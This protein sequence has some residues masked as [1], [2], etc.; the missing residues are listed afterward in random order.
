MENIA[1]KTQHLGL[2]HDGKSII[3]GLNLLIHTGEITALI[4]PNGCGKSTLLR[5]AV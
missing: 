3:S 4:D 1:L 2:A 5:R